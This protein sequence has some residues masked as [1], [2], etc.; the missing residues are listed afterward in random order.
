MSSP[1]LNMTTGSTEAADASHPLADHVKHCDLWCDDGSIVVAAESTIFRV[2]L[3]LPN[4]KH[5]EFFREMFN[6]PHLKA[7]MTFDGVPIVEFPH[8]A[9]DV[10]HFPKAIID[11]AFVIRQFYCSIIFAHDTRRYC[12]SL[13]PSLK[14]QALLRLSTQYG[15]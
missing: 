14:I 5:S 15:N 12:D 13:R 7:D 11:P 4:K 6:M 8:S 9:E 2:Y 10:V 1:D 3:C